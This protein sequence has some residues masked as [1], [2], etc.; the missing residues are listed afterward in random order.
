MVPLDPED[1]RETLRRLAPAAAPGLLALKHALAFRSPGLWGDAPTAPRS[2]L[3]VR[4]GD[5]RLEAFGAGEPEPSV[6]WLVGQ[7]RRFS[8]VAPGAWLD[9]VRDRL[10]AVDE[11]AV[12]TWSGGPGPSNPPSVVARR[13]TSHDLAGFLA[14]SPPWGLRGWRSYPA[15]IAH[16]AAFGVTHGPGFAALAWVFDR[17]DPYDAVSVYT[18]PRY[19]RL[20]LGRAAASA[21]TAHIVHGCG[22]V[23][24]W[25]T[26]TDN[27]P[28]RA[29]ARSLGFSPAA[30]ETV[31]RWPPRSSGET[32]DPREETGDR[33][34]E[35]GGRQ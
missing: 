3:L 11:D 27:A 12:E 7:L 20:G 16:A 30:V 18:V 28:S 9:A 8:L 21:L 4:E 10:G 34:Q 1:T 24:L 6:G 35:T 17:A 23:P 19:R 26:R 33:R 22:R 29:L 5:G 14:A 25:S 31:V 13:L 32:G 15:M 2:V